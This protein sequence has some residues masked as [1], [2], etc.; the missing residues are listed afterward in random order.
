MRFLFLLIMFLTGCQGYTCN[1]DADC[2]DSYACRPE[3]EEGRIDPVSGCVTRCEED[4]DCSAGTVCL[5]DG[6]CG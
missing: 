1:V 3:L 5:S 2:S 6:S 4:A